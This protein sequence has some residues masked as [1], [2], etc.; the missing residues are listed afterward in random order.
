MSS[1]NIVIVFVATTSNM[2]AKMPM[3][4]RATPSYMTRLATT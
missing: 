3:W 1:P 4:A 2:F